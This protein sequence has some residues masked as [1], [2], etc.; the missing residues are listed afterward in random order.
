MGDTK[1]SI[2]KTNSET[3]NPIEKNGFSNNQS[4]KII[5]YQFE[6]LAKIRGTTAF[7]A[8]QNLDINLL[9]PADYSKVISTNDIE[10]GKLDF[11]EDD[12]N[13]TSEDVKFKNYQ[14]SSKIQ[15]Q[16]MQDIEFINKIVHK[17]QNRTNEIEESKKSEIKAKKC[18]R[19]ADK[20]I[21]DEINQEHGHEAQYDLRFINDKKL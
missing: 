7:S 19:L 4:K 10:N 16:I 14:E 21:K 9:S 6:N 17:N 18:N 3:I 20:W 12:K 8:N 1:K 11:F 13:K 15:G 5:M 2:K